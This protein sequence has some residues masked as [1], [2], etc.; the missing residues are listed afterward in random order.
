MVGLSLGFWNIAGMRQKLE[1]DRVRCW[2]YKHDIII[3]SETK[4]KGTPSVPGFV[5]VNNSKSNHGGIVAFIKVWL[6]P[7]I[8]KID[9]SIEGVI[10]LELSCAPGVRLIG[11]YNEPTD[12]LYFRP[13][14][15]A[16][17]PAHVSSGKSC[18]VV[19]DLN[20]RFG[21]LVGDIVEDSPELNYAVIDNQTDSNGR[22]LARICQNN[23][24][25]PVNNLRTTNARWNSKLT[26]RRKGNWISEVDHCLVHRSMVNNIQTFDVLHDLTMPSDHAPITISFNFLEGG[27]FENDDLL[28][29]SS[30]LGSYPCYNG[31]PQDKCRKP[32]PYRR[33]DKELFTM[34]LL[35]TPP[36]V[37]DANDIQQSLSSFEETIYNTARDHQSKET[38]LY[39]SQDKQKTR[40]KRIL[41]A[42]DTKS[43]WQG[44]D[45]KGE[46]REV[47]SKDRPSEVVFQEHMERLLNPDD[48]ED[49]QYPGPNHVSIPALDDPFRYEELDHVIQKQMK[50]DKSCGP[51]GNSPGTLKLLPLQ[52]LLFILTLF[53]TVFQVGTYPISWSL[54]KLI[55]LFK[56]GLPMDCGNYR[57]IGIINA[58]A[59]CYEYMITN[60]LPLWYTPCREQGGAQSKR[61]V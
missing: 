43:L 31:K 22:T 18:I 2:L 33:I 35:E 53:N 9:V 42:D 39:S 28:E 11:M 5:T 3:I 29:R 60:R 45:W 27:F 51:N 4:T 30:L 58:L 25:V 48:V 55:M 56:K 16:S 17:I 32:I 37:L 49:L 26:F 12:S 38:I 40:W 54:S 47:E 1:N 44:I 36:P 8:S 61:G 7:Q 13:T 41:E 46:F 14:T 21:N 50:P 10:A 23:E 6:Y 59:K 57:G 34:K 19:G 20:S 52:W 15:L 24:L